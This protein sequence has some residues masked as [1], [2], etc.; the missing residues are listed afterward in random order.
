[1]RT[2]RLDDDLGHPHRLPPKRT[3]LTYECDRVP[4]LDEQREVVC[5]MLRCNLAWKVLERTSRTSGPRVPFRL[6]A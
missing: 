2:A 1:M 4:I 6:D 5:P 3:P